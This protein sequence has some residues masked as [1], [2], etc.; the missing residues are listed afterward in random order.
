MREAVQALLLLPLLEQHLKTVAQEVC[1]EPVPHRVK[2][3][4]MQALE[5]V[6]AELQM[7]TMEAHMQASLITQALQEEAVQGVA[8]SPQL[9]GL[10]TPPHP[11]STTAH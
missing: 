4:C 11:D 5:A 1:R 8:V 9:F 10:S 3:V 2:T 7:L 6:Q